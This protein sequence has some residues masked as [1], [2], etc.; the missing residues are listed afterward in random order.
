[1][2]KTSNDSQACFWVTQTATNTLRSTP[3]KSSDTAER[4]TTAYRGLRMRLWKEIQVLSESSSAQ[5]YGNRCGWWNSTLSI[6]FLDSHFAAR[7]SDKPGLLA[8]LGRP[9]GPLDR[10]S[11]PIRRGPRFVSLQGPSRV[12]VGLSA[13]RRRLVRDSEGQ[14]SWRVGSVSSLAAGGS[15]QEADQA[16]FKLL[17]R[18]RSDAVSWACKSWQQLG[19]RI[20]KSGCKERRIPNDMPELHQDEIVEL[21]HSLLVIAEL[22]AMLMTSSWMLSDGRLGHF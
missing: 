10:R 15:R 4:N 14:D 11:R 22:L 17:Q 5:I 7:D 16:P 2:E 1:M 20:V 19:S 3:S 18:S 12:N 6:E 9:F 8:Y 21:L 13:D